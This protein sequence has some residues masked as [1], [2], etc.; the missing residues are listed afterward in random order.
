VRKAIRDGMLLGGF[1][2]ITD[3]ARRL[4][5]SRSTLQRVLAESGLTF[6]GL[7]RDVRVEF[8]AELLA[9]GASWS[10]TAERVGLGRDHLSRLIKQ[11]FNVRPHQIERVNTLAGTLTRATIRSA[12]TGRLLSTRGEQQWRELE[13]EVEEVL[14]RLPS[15]SHG[16]SAWERRVRRRVRWPGDGWDDRVTGRTRAGD[17]SRRRASRRVR[18]GDALASRVHKAA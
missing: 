15:G 10:E 2:P 1:P 5:L 11:R 3:V 7:R 14:R 4:Y 8:A 16:L 9:R 18:Q 17:P 13:T 12:R 6:T